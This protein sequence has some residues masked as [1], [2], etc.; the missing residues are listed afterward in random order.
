MHIND[1]ITTNES[2]NQESQINILKADN[3]RLT[4]LVQS[5]K[6]DYTKKLKNQADMF[7]HLLRE[8]KNV[9]KKKLTSALMKGKLLNRQKKRLNAKMTELLKKAKE[10]KIL[11]EESYDILNSEFE[12]TFKH[13]VQNEKLNK[14]RVCQGKRYKEE[15]KKFALTLYYHSPKAYYFCRY[16]CMFFYFIHQHFRTLLV[17]DLHF[18]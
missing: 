15:V 7:H 16:V 6:D 14:N 17:K 2:N 4:D 11:H 5:L 12:S 10:K 9:M 8:Q 1:Y 3:K 13:I 18:S